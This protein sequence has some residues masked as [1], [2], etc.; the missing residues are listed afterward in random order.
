MKTAHHGLGGT[1][2]RFIERRKFSPNAAYCCS[3]TPYNFSSSSSSDNWNFSVIRWALWSYLGFIHPA[4]LIHEL[5]PLP[6]EHILWWWHRS[7]VLFQDVTSLV[8]FLSISPMGGK[9]ATNTIQQLKEMSKLEFRV[10][11]V[12]DHPAGHQ[13]YTKCERYSYPY[14]FLI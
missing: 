12:R 5:S 7:R 2:P 1:G 13:F 8:P 10:V 6:Q 9:S 11:V 14:S 3:A 4:G